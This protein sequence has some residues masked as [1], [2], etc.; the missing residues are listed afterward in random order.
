MAE[1]I[2]FTDLIAF[3]KKMEGETLNTLYQ[4]KPFVLSK[5]ES[6]KLT[7]IPLSKKQIKRTQD[8]DFI[9][10]ILDRYELTGSLRPGDYIDLTVNASYILPLINLYLRS[11]ENK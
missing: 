10:S 7:Y 8:R 5:V 9:E 11:K 3:C 1:R 2:D 4:K 6:E